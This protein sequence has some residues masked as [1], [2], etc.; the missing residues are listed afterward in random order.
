MAFK[1]LRGGAA[2]QLLS[3]R[4]VPLTHLGHTDPQWTLLPHP[5]PPRRAEVARFLRPS[6]E[7]TTSRQFSWSSGS[8]SAKTHSARSLCWKEGTHLLSHPPRV[9][10]LDPGVNPCRMLTA[11][12]VR[13]LGCSRGQA[14]SH[15][16]GGPGWVSPPEMGPRTRNQ[17]PLL[18]VQETLIPSGKAPVEAEG[19]RLCPLGSP[20]FLVFSECGDEGGDCL[21]PPPPTAPHAAVTLLPAPPA[22]APELTRD[23]GRYRSGVPGSLC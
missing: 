16:P 1:A 13:A 5:P 15:L 19:P 23:S 10:W 7:V 14:L 20:G 22:G 21:P 4:P 9:P 12:A 3:C 8:L 17:L 11:R 6:T 2:S 18:C